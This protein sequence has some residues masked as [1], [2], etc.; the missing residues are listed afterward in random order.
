MMKL[1][2]LFVLLILVLAT[3]ILRP[4]VSRSI[5]KYS[6]VEASEYLENANRMLAQWSN[7]VVQADWNWLTNL[8]NEN[9]EKKVL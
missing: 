1:H 5:N 8:T 4:V 3:A 7:R 9:A 2:Q 6:E